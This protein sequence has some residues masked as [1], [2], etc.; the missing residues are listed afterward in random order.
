MGFWYSDVEF[1]VVSVITYTAASLTRSAQMRPA[2]TSRITFRISGS[3]VQG[4]TH[5]LTDQAFRI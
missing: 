3:A 4:R 2:A 5:M 1:E